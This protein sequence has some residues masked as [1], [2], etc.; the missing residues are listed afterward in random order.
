MLE[1]IDGL[2]ELKILEALYTDKGLCVQVGSSVSQI[3]NC[4]QYV[5]RYVIK[6]EPSCLASAI[7]VKEGRCLK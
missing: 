1:K 3:K 7:P 6:T 5:E 4:L 2:T